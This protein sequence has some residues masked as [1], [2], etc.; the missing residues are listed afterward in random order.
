MP[1]LHLSREQEPNDERST[2]SFL[3][4]TICT[5]G[6]PTTAGSA[7]LESFKPS[8]DAT[9]VAHL[10]AAGASILGKAN[11][12]QFAMGSTTET[13]HHHVS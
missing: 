1:R 4:D 6:I 10:K 2:I 9:S 7:V 3:Q 11:C 13:S 5:S 12:D 8:F